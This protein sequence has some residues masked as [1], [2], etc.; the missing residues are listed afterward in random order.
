MWEKMLR[1]G[2]E[3]PELSLQSK[4]TWQVSGTE[5]DEEMTGL[6]SV[7]EVKEMKIEFDVFKKLSPGQAVLIDKF[8]HKEDLFQVWRPVL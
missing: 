8:F 3:L 2:L 6:G 5:T 1:N 4:K 7:R